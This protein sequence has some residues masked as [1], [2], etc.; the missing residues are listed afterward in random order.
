MEEIVEITAYLLRKV[1]RLINDKNELIKENA[2]LARQ[3]EEMRP[4]VKA[5]ADATATVAKN[6]K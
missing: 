5:D 4:Y 1:V 6:K 2:R 3:I